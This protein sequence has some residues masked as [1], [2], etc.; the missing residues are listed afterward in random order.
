MN[1]MTCSLRFASTRKKEPI[2]VSP[3]SSGK[4][5]ETGVLMFSLES[6]D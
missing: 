3:S 4:G 1:S 6:D 5:P 2:I